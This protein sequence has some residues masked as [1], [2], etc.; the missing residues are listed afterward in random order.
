MQSIISI[1]TVVFN[2]VL[3]IE[4]SIK[5]VLSQ[6]VRNFQYIVIDGGST[7]GTV[8]VVEKYLDQ[9]DVFLSEKDEGIYDAM[10]K[11]ISLAKGNFLYFLGADDFLYNSFV[12]KNIE[13]YTSQDN[14]DLIFGDVKYDTGDF[15]RSKFDWTLLLHNSLHHQ[16]TFYNVKLFDQFRYDTSFRLISDYELN[17]KLYLN[18]RN[19]VVKKVPLTISLCS[20]NGAS[21]SM[22]SIA[23]RET[24]QIRE[25]CLGATKSFIFSLLYKLKLKLWH[26]RHNQL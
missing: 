17:L 11:G 26:V 6:N 23:L 8:E 13:Y 25:K 19:L 2:G 3:T 18:K 22:L 10:N 5:S 7:D 20:D 21:R 12:T 24:N 14:C 1:I 15:V 9:I 16:G 4:N